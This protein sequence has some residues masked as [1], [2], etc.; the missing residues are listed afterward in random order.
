MMTSEDQHLYQN[1]QSYCVRGVCGNS[2]ILGYYPA[3][4]ALRLDPIE[5]LRYE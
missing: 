2:G 3:Q 4:K 1:L 5:A